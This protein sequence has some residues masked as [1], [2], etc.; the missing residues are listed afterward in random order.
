[1]VLVD[2][3]VV[4]RLLLVDC[5]EGVELRT[6]GERPIACKTACWWRVAAEDVIT[7]AVQVVETEVT[8]AVRLAPQVFSVSPEWV[9]IPATRLQVAQLEMPHT[10]K[11][12]Q[13]AVTL[14][15][16]ERVA[17]LLE[18]VAVAVIMEGGP[19]IAPEVGVARPT[20]PLLT[21][22]FKMAKMRK[23]VT[24]LFLSSTT[25]P[26]L[27]RELLLKIP[28]VLLQHDQLLSL[29]WFPH[30]RLQQLQLLIP[31]VIPP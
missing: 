1:M 17:V 10:V 25:P 5:L 13:V 19:D 16:A 29:Q 11:V 4:A 30:V 26:R 9:A 24:Q 15:R 27:L 12:G 22:R 8:L 7:R 21:F 23:M 28:L 20:R 2:P 18:W 3:T 31:R 6:S 14:V